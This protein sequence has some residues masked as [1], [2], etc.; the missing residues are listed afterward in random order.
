MAVLSIEVLEI[1]FVNFVQFLLNTAIFENIFPKHFPFIKI[2]C[3]KDEI[4]FDFIQSE[5]LLIINR[6]EA[7]LFLIL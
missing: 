3:G 6:D 1:H 5:Q 2:K 7:A 4:S